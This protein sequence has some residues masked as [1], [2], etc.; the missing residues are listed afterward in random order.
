[1]L[2]KKQE[3]SVLKE[4]RLPEDTPK[5]SK[6]Y[7]NSQ[8]TALPKSTSPNAFNRYQRSQRKS[9]PIVRSNKSAYDHIQGSK[10]LKLKN[11]NSKLELLYERMQIGQINTRN[12]FNKNF[13]DMQWQLEKS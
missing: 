10:T 8:E 13:E 9:E 1:M 11:I 5:S 6:Y 7:Q 12:Y 2:G 3:I 4:T